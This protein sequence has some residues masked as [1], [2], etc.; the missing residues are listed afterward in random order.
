MELM[1]F[2]WNES[3]QEN[4]LFI[5]EL[6]GVCVRAASQDSQVKFKVRDTSNERKK[7]VGVET[8]ETKL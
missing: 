8:M 5:V 2:Q 7:D 3:F 1:Q 6:Y 4:W